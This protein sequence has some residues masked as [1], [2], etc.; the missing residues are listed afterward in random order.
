MSKPFRIL[1]VCL[2]NICRSPAAEGVMRHLVEREGLRDGVEIDSAGTGDWHTG[3]LP[4]ARMR[5]HAAKRGYL[6][7]SRARQ[8]RT[9][10]FAAFD[11]IVAMDRDNLRNLRDFAGSGEDMNRVKLFC[12]FTT[13]HSRKDVPDPYY[14][15]PD[16]FGTVLDL[17]ENGCAGIL[18]KIR[19]DI[20]S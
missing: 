11:L 17:V 3:D 4:D 13:G 15:G 9:E 20:G 19:E 1:F 2:G 14:G 18:R 10:D 12:E 6:L 16:G 5:Q 8:V 7:T